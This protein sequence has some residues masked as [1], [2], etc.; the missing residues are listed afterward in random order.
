MSI[1]IKEKIV[2]EYY[3]NKKTKEITLD[4]DDYTEEYYIFKQEYNVFK[5]NGKVSKTY[6]SEYD[7]VNKEAERLLTERLRLKSEIKEDEK[8][9]IELAKIVRK[10][11]EDM[12]NKDSESVR[13]IDWNYVQKEQEFDDSLTPGWV[14]VKIK[15]SRSKWYQSY[16]GFGHSPS[17]YHYQV[18]IC[19]EKEAKELQKIREKHQDDDTF[20]FEICVYPKRVIREADHDC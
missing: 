11:Y 8:R 2:V 3:K 4:Y 9:A 20:N 18:P 10:A 6:M 7:C 13:A 14:T 16:T 1:I 17:F 15:S 12:I 5:N 19:V